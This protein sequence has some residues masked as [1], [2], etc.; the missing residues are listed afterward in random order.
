MESNV[1]RGPSGLIPLVS[2]RGHLFVLCNPDA[3]ES[4][5]TCEELTKLHV[6][7]GHVDWQTFHA[8]ITRTCPGKII[9]K[10]RRQLE[11]MQKACRACK[12]YSSAP[13]VFTARISHDG[14]WFNSEIIVDLFYFA[15]EAAVSVVNRET[16]FQAA[17]FLKVESAGSVWQVIIQCWILVFV[18]PPDSILHDAGSNFMSKEL[19]KTAGESGIICHPVAIESAH[20]MGVGERYHGVVRRVYNRVAEAHLD[21]DAE[22]FLDAAI[23]AINDTAG[24]DGL[25]PTLLVFGEILKVPLTGSDDG[26]VAKADRLAA[27]MLVREEYSKIVDEQRLQVI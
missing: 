14:I 1:L 3:F 21:L 4:F 24:L 13:R 19:K 9:Y 8:F 18:G 15:E 11:A 5:F 26:S 6:R 25:I 27:M 17:M 10:T 20:F 2:Q 23:K 7:T 22:L 12:K 16:K